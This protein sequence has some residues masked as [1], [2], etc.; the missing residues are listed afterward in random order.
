MARKYD[1]SEIIGEVLADTPEA[2]D[3]FAAYGLSCSTCALNGIDSIN[4]GAKLHGMEDQEVK[5]MLEDLG[6]LSGE[7][8]RKPVNMT[9]AARVALLLHKAEMD[10]EDAGLY[11]DGKN[12]ET[13]FLDF[14]EA[15]PAGCTVT[16]CDGLQF[17]LTSSA[18]VFLRSHS[19]D[20]EESETGGAFVFPLL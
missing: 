10:V 8:P 9:E 13:I 2:Q 17:F 19:I 5:L 12:P 20:F 14:T 18:Q 1:G 16:F 7:K 4:E 11:I 3:V 15:P 6:S